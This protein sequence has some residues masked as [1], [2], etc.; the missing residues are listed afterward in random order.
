MFAIDEPISG[1]SWAERRAIERNRAYKAARKCCTRPSFD[2][3]ELDHRSTLSLCLFFHPFPPPFP[4][5]VSFAFRRPNPHLL[6]PLLFPLPADFI[7][8]V[9]EGETTFVHFSNCDRSREDSEWKSTTRAERQIAPRSVPRV[10][11]AS[12]YR[13]PCCWKLT[14]LYDFNVWR[15]RNVRLSNDTSLRVDFYSFVANFG[16]NNCKIERER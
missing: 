13:V 14:V 9:P 2:I 6:L 1:Q 12:F 15:G 5:A 10:P 7:K 4:P 16:V 8:P 3:I 11:S